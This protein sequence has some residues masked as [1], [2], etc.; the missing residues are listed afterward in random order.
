MASIYGSHA[1]LDVPNAPYMD[2]PRW[3]RSGSHPTLLG[4][5]RGA[6][7]PISPKRPMVTLTLDYVMPAAVIFSQP[8]MHCAHSAAI[9]SASHAMHE[10]IPSFGNFHGSIRYPVNVCMRFFVCHLVFED[11]FGLFQVP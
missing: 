10:T 7:E 3:A 6:Y 1:P 4:V 2:G 5:L 9:S 11:V 8:R